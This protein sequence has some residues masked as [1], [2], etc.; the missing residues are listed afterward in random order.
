MTSSNWFQKVMLL[1]PSCAYPLAGGLLIGSVIFGSVTNSSAIALEWQPA[2]ED[3]GESSSPQETL[4]SD[5]LIQTLRALDLMKMLA[6]TSVGNQQVRTVQEELRTV[7]REQSSPYALSASQGQ[8]LR[9]VF[10]G[11]SEQERT[12]INQI[13]LLQ[14]AENSVSFS[15]TEVSYLKQALNGVSEQSLNSSQREWLAL[16]RESLG[17]IPPQRGASFSGDQVEVLQS[18]IAQVF[19]TTNPRSNQ[20]VNQTEETQS[21]NSNLQPN[22]GSNNSNSNI[23]Q[24]PDPN[25][26]NNS[27]QSQYQRQRFR[28]NL[29]THLT[30][31]NPELQEVLLSSLTDSGISQDNAQSLIGSIEN[32][33]QEVQGGE[34]FFRVEMARRIQLAQTTFNETLPNLERET[35][36]APPDSL[37]T[38]REV[39]SEAVEATRSA[40]EAGLT[41][42][43][44]PPEEL[45]EATLQSREEL[46]DRLL[47]P[48]P[49]TETIALGQDRTAPALGIN[50]PS[51]F[52]SEWGQVFAGV[53]YQASTRPVPPS[54]EPNDEDGAFAV[55]MGFGDSQ[56]AV[57]LEATYASFGTFRSGAFSTG[58]V[59]FKLHRR[60]GNTSSVAVGVENLIQYGGADGQTSYYGSVTNVFNLTEDPTD[61]FSRLVVTAGLGSGR[62]REF[63]DT[64]EGN[65]TINVFGSV[66]L[67]VAEPV[68]ILAA[69]TGQTLTIGTSVAPF[70]NIPLVI[71]PSVTDIT[72]D[73]IDSPRFVITIGYGDRLFNKD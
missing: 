1:H 70:A 22:S 5:E 49:T 56:E 42:G 50:V 10:S 32:M 61:A 20:A 69:Y 66:G 51:G 17:K 11:L 9:N 16:I 65:D 25:S 43:I 2:P 31:S 58:S 64:V 28:S 41:E 62:F 27:N 12:A 21:S 14:Q 73:F 71:T 8:Q 68:S 33:F 24:F 3:R 19:F 38:I 36:E 72:S 48:D 45:A 6:L 35:L 44:D 53:G 59:S 15:A 47:I 63:Q 23:A 30:N 46:I 37:L 7:A 39:I 55:G 34:V 4:T 52:G 26:S 18:A 54:T 13:L 57:G 29:A 67:Q 60:L 40:E